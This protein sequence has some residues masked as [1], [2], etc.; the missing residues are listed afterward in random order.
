MQLIIV[1]DIFGKT[2]ELISFSDNFKKMYQTIRIVDPYGGAINNFKDEQAAYDSFQTNC[3]LALFSEKVADAIS[4]S[5]N[6]IDLIGFSVGASAIWKISE[7]DL[8]NHIKNAFCFY[9]SKIRDLV[10]INPTFFITLIFPKSE[11]HFSIE[12]LFS[13]IVKKKNV[14]C[15]MTIYNHGF[16]NQRSVNYNEDAYKMF[17]DYIKQNIT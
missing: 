10:H 7:F 14:Y 12:A 13:E 11:K 9:G 6:S 8:P 17:T 4:L 3:S 1:S 15:E 2:P 16:M 5:E